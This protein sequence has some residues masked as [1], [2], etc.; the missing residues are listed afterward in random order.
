V[1]CGGDEEE[2]QQELQMI[3]LCLA[4]FRFKVVVFFSWWEILEKDR[5]T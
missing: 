3:P 2:R 4:N 5:R 1:L